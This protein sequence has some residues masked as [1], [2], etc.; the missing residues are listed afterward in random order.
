[1]EGSSRAV[2]A[3]GADALE[4]NFSCPHGS[5]ELGGLSEIG[6]HPFLMAKVLGWVRQSTTLPVYVKLPPVNNLRSTHLQTLGRRW[7]FYDQYNKLLP[8]RY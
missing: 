1:M 8:R 3:D 4:L 7:H 2:P 5:A 6:M